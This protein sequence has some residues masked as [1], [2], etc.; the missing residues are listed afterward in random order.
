MTINRRH[1][2]GRP[3]AEAPQTLATFLRTCGVEPADTLACRISLNPQ[4]AGDEF[5]TTADLL[6]QKCVLTYARM[7]DGRRLGADRDVLLFLAEPA[8]IAR[9][10]GHFHFRARR[11]GI[12]PGDIVYD[13][14]AAHLLHSFIAR[15]HHP[16]FY[17][18]FEIAGL[19]AFFGTLTVRWPAPMMRAIRRADDEAIT[20]APA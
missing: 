12:A 1:G 17:D 3:V 9:L 15:A 10:F 8:G 19:E 16:T 20:V 2:P 13:Y 18:A 11:K 14:D 6:R 5:R 4:D 7:Q